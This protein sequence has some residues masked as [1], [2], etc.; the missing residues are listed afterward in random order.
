MISIDNIHTMDKKRRILYN[1][2]LDH[3]KIVFS[4]LKLQL[5]IN[6][7]EQKKRNVEYKSIFTFNFSMLKCHHFPNHRKNIKCNECNKLTLSSMI[8]R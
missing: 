6:D 4:K 2:I 1:I 8:K 3:H 7:D 5:E